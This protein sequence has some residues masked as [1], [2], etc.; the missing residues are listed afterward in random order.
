[1]VEEGFSLEGTSAP[2][3]L[4]PWEG[5][6]DFILGNP[7]WFE[8]WVIG[9]QNCEQPFLWYIHVSSF[10]RSLVIEDRYNE[11]ISSPDAWLVAD[12]G[13][14][15]EDLRDLRPT[16]SARKVKGLVEQV[17]GKVVFI[18]LAKSH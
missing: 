4:A 10:D 3:P 18:V 13:E 15:T 1:M 2:N 7:H 9:E 12:Q 17:T 6:S 16:N 14:G 11:L 5:I 8:T